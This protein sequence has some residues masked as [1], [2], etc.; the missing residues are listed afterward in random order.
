MSVRSL[1][2]VPE[3]RDRLDQILPAIPK[4]PSVPLRVSPRTNRFALVGTAFDYALRFELQRLNP[5]AI[6]RH[7]VA[8]GAV[9]RISEAADRAGLSRAQARAFEKKGA[10]IL[11][12]ARTFLDGYRAEPD[13]ELRQLAVHAL[14]LA[15]LDNVYRAYQL[16]PALAEV[17]PDDR[18]DV[19]E[20]VSVVPFERLSHPKVLLLN[21]TFG[22]HSAVAGGADADLI[23][24]NL[25]VEV[26]TTKNPELKRD[27]VRQLLVYFMLARRARAEDGQIPVIDRLGIYFSRHAHLWELLTASITA[28][29]E[30]AATEGWLIRYAARTELD[31]E[32][33][34]LWEMMQEDALP[35]SPAKPRRSKPIADRGTFPTALILMAQWRPVGPSPRT[36]AILRPTPSSRLSRFDAQRH[37][38]RQA[39]HSPGREQVSIKSRYGVG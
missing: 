7:W 37:L 29:P 34:D 39:M 16:D 21:P 15:K 36:G 35:A 3:V 24:G 30:Y 2:A 38:H 17:D 33:R 27:M 12:D 4:L 22:M 9:E 19:A 1:I 6:A 8:D 32:L 10:K 13:P 14:L 20:L 25:L 23:C 26:K 11:A 5:H 18:D 31:P 28:K